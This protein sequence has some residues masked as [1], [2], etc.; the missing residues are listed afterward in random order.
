MRNVEIKKGIHWVGALDPEL[1]VFDIIMYTPFGTS[2][3]SYVVKGSEKIALFETVKEKCFDKY[4]ETLETLNITPA[5]IDY[6]VVDHTE[7]DHSGSVGKIL[8]LAPHAKVVG[9]MQAI[10][11][12]KEIINRDFDYIIAKDGDTLS[13]GDKTLRFISAPFLHWPDS[14]YTYVEEDKVLITCDSFGCHYSCENIFNDLVENEEDYNVSLKYYFD[15]IFGPFKPFVLKGIDKIK[16]L[17]IDIIC[18]GH[19]PILRENPWDVVNKFK[20]WATPVKPIINGD[21]KVT[22]CYVS[23]YG[24]T[25][26][27]AK[28]IEEGLKKNHNVEVKLYDLTKDK[29]NDAIMKDINESD[30]LLFGSPTIVGELLPPIRILLANLNP[31]ING[32]KFAAAFGSYGW[33]GEAVPRIE[34]RLEELKMKLVHPGLRVKFRASKEQIDEAIE[35]GNNFSKIMFGE[36]NINPVDHG[37]C[38]VNKK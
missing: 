23:A 24:Y 29:D 37:Q 17:D 8:D 19:G 28:Y 15:A 2:Y 12:L 18:P 35:F 5:D 13:L 34:S 16:D 32:K 20:E 7:P 30:G 3:N 38:D 31:I 9:S 21:K 22:I 11:F 14:M 25:E 1:R 10:S 33:S 4:L 26:E 36:K 27:L 6:I